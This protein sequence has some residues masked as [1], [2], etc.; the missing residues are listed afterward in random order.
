MT[1]LRWGLMRL[2][3]RKTTMPPMTEPLPHWT[4][5]DLE[6]ALGQFDQTQQLEMLRSHLLNG[7]GCRY[8]F[9]ETNLRI[10]SNRTCPRKCGC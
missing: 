9:V 3:Q 1:W 10:L 2:H 8:E 5:D 7:C 4:W 6:T